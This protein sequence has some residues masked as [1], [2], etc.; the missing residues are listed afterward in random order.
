MNKNLMIIAIATICLA[1]YM[2]IDGFENDSLWN[3]NL[4]F[5]K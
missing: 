1:I 3:Y 5:T 4:T 2:I